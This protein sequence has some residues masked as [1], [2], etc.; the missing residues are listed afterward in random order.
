MA[1]ANR[2]SE[3]QSWQVLSEC[4]GAE[5]IV[6]SKV[7]AV[8]KMSFSERSLSDFSDWPVDYLAASKNGTTQQNSRAR[9]AIVVVSCFPSLDCLRLNSAFRVFE[10]LQQ[11]IATDFW[12]LSDVSVRGDFG[13]RKHAQMVRDCLRQLPAAIR[14]KSRPISALI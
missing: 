1:G 7:L 13:D 11:V 9:K 3:S 6:S 5:V 8:C 14:T 2:T 12:T 10:H 4:A